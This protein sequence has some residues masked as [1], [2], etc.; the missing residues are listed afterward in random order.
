MEQALKAYTKRIEEAESIEKIKSATDIEAVKTQQK[1]AAQLK[2][3]VQ[4]MQN[5]LDV[6][7][8]GHTSTAEYQNALNA[9]AKAYPEAANAEGIMID[10]AQAFIDAE[11]LKADQ[12]WNASQTTIQGNIAAVQTF[13]DLANAAANDADMQ[14]QLAQA[15]GIDY[16]QIIPTLTS[17][18][19]ILQQ[20]GGQTPT[21]VPRSSSNSFIKTKNI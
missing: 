16:A 11:A 8:L 1:E 7:K 5:Y 4:E 9:L 12:A 19:N 15:I 21:Q 3:N 2:V 13:I 6:I 10:Q 20:I 14:A 17:V 18:L